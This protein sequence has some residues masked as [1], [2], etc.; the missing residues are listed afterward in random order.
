MTFE[1]IEGG[2]ILVSLSSTPVM[3]QWQLT[4]GQC[5]AVSLHG[6]VESGATGM[7][8]EILPVDLIECY[9]V[10]PVPAEAVA[11]DQ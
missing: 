7:P 6:F 3:K 11:R 10:A 8:V 5:L 1:D 2:K 4:Q 9:E